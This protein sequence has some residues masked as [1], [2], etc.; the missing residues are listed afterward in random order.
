[1]SFDVVVA[2]GNV[3]VGNAEP[4]VAD[5]GIVDGTIRAIGEDLRGEEVIDARGKLVLPGAVDAHY[6]LGIYR[7]IG[8]DAESE[9]L[10]SLAGGVTSVVSYFRTGSHYLN[11]T[12]PYRE[13]FPEV[14]ELAAGRARTDFAY[15]L[16]PMDRAQVAE[17]PALVERFGIRS[18]K[19]YMFYKG[20]DLAGVGD[21]NAYRMSDTYDLGHLLEIMEAVAAVQERVGLA[22]RVSLSIHAEQ[23]ELI[24]VFM[25]RVRSAGELTGLEAYSAG[26]PPLT[27][28]LAIGEAGVLAHATACPIQFL[29]LSSAEALRSAIEFERAHRDLDV[30]LEVTLHHLALSYETYADQRGKVNPPIRSEADREALW[31]GLVRGDVDWVCSDHACC[32]EENKEGDMWAALPG[33]GGSALLYPYLLTEGPAARPLDPA[34]RRASGDQPGAGVRARAGEGRDRARRRR[35][36]GRRRHGGHPR[37][38]RR[39]PALGAGLHAV[40]GH[41]ADGLAGSDA[42]ARPGGAARRRAGRRPGRG[43]PAGRRRVEGDPACIALDLVLPAGDLDERRRQAA[44]LRAEEEERAVA[45]VHRPVLDARR[46][47]EVGA[48]VHH[49]AVPEQDVAAQHQALLDRRVHLRATRQPAGDDGRHPGPVLREGVLAQEL[50]RDPERA[51]GV[52]SRH[53]PRDPR[54]VGDLDAGVPLGRALGLDH[55]QDARSPRRSRAPAPSALHG[56]RRTRRQPGRKAEAAAISAAPVRQN[57]STGETSTPTT[58]DQPAGRWPRAVW[59]TSWSSALSNRRVMPANGPSRTDLPPGGRPLR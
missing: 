53:V 55:D 25:E 4:V 1:M 21:A 9:T 44:A 20:I 33:F 40:R 27:E 36:P 35:R 41:G 37:G 8:D 11:K 30:R 43:L 48:R 32:S 51:I 31:A 2:G 3:V 50:D 15:H 58:P 34:D 39:A 45:A 38:H 56:A 14:L 46:A 47:P 52:R 19:Y 17:I 26:R 18:F 42:A 57:S 7:S 54:L 59:S 16:A 22:E 13:I 23:P 49:A 28:R 29:H 5:I 12:G 6:H 10:S 24:R